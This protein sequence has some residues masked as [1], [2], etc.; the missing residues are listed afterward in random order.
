MKYSILDG[1]LKRYDFSALVPCSSATREIYLTR[2]LCNI[3]PL[4]SCTVTSHWLLIN[5]I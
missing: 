4:T 1:N 3:R 5:Y 2:I